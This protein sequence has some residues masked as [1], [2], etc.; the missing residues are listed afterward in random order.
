M[1]RFVIVSVLLVT[2]SPGWAQLTFKTIENAKFEVVVV[3]G[4][5]RGRL[6]V[7]DMECDPG[8]DPIIMIMGLGV[9]VY[10]NIDEP[11]N[12]S[13][14]IKMKRGRADVQYDTVT[15]QVIK[16]RLQ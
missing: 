1:I 6:I 5:D 11:L 7:R 14:F 10:V 9:P 12:M 13:E 15:N 8:C 3:E 4:N 2:V 16:V